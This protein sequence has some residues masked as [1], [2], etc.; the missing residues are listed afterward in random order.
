MPVL[1]ARNVLKR[2]LFVAP[3]AMLTLFAGQAL[4]A[5]PAALNR[6]PKNAMLVI[7]TDNFEKT[8]GRIKSYAEKLRAEDTSDFDD[9]VEELTGTKG[10]KKDGSLALVVMA[11]AEDAEK[12]EAKKEGDEDADNDGPRHRDHDNPM[13]RAVVLAQTTDYKELVTELGGDPAEKVSK[14]EGLGEMPMFVRDIGDGWVI[15]GPV[16]ETVAGFQPG[17]KMLKQHEE[18]L[19]VVGNRAAQAS[20]ILMVANWEAI[21][22]IFGKQ[23]DR[24]VADAKK[25]G[26]RSNPMFGPI[27]PETIAQFIGPIEEVARA[28]NR[29]AQTCVAG[30]GLGDDG[31]SVDLGAQFKPKSQIAGFFQS[32]GKAD[33]TL[34]SLPA[35]PFLFAVS[36]D[37]SNPGTRQMIHNAADITEKMLTTAKD[38]AKR[39]QA[40]PDKPASKQAETM[41][42]MF[43]SQTAGVR[44]LAKSIDKIDGVDFIWGYSPAML[45]GA[46]LFSGG[47]YQGRGSDPEALKAIFVDQ[48]K[49]TQNMDGPMKMEASFTPNAAEV[50]G[51]KLDAWTLKPKMDPNDPAAS[52]M[53]MVNMFIFGATGQM[54]G[55]IATT[56]NAAIVTYSPNTQVMQMA[57]DAAAGKGTIAGD[58]GVA[59]AVKGLP[60]G[61]WARGLI[62]TKSLFDLAQMAMSFTG[63]PIQLKVPADVPPMAVGMTGDG[64]GMHIRFHAPMQVISTVGDV[65]EQFR[66]AQ[67]H[68]VDDT[69]DEK[70]RF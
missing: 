44:N 54:S 57:L 69:P 28:Y 9:F 12:K 22:P 13:E 33:N 30:I 63:M 61:S 50:G 64:G 56:K 41:L 14:V 15:F 21:A 2:K 31:L 24:A 6:V 39:Q 55:N 52:Q 38:E 46:G 7:A 58:K 66:D 70:P 53:A 68:E 25:G 19:G 5:V 51:V 27:P 47:I 8:A 40:N 26:R 20:D 4:A 42:K 36:A 35:T 62:G 34:N 18:A 3:I 10:F 17:E 67:K 60:E 16:E 29:D 11:P 23:I 43:E 37:T 1:R 48:I 45:A 49:A 32:T 59:T 65:L